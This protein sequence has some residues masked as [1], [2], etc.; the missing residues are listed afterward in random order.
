MTAHPNCCLLMMVVI[1][2]VFPMENM[3]ILESVQ[4]ILR[5]GVLCLD[6]S[7][8]VFNSLIMSH[9]TLNKAL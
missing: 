3:G 8:P 9:Y 1:H 7:D 6:V 5:E 4:C 2:E